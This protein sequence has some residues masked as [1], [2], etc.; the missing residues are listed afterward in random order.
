MDN[1]LLALS[2]RYFSLKYRK[3]SLLDAHKVDLLALELIDTEIEKVGDMIE[4][5][6]LI[7]TY[8]ESLKA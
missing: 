4:N 8:L 3:E 6:H 2:K 5:L 7:E 1:E